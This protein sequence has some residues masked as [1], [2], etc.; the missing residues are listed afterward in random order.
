MDLFS[1]DHLQQSGILPLCPS[2]QFAIVKYLLYYFLFNRGI[3]TFTVLNKMKSDEF[4]RLIERNGW[5][6]LRK[7]GSHVI[8][9]KGSRTYPVPY[10]GSKEMGIGIVK[11]ISNDMG[12]K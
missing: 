4:H 7:A 8:Y 2:I 9:K 11:K 1:G 10:H 5:T 3:T 12:L 6:Y